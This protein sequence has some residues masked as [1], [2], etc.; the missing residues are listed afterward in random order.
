[1]NSGLLDGEDMIIASPT[2]SGKTLIA[3]L[4]MINKTVKKDETAIYIVPLKSL[5]S[6]KF[7]D[8]KERFEDQKVHISVGDLDDS[9]EG[10]ET[11]DIVVVTSEKLDS[12]LRHNPSWINNIGLVVVDEIHLLTSEERGTTLEV[13][14]SRLQELLEFQLL[15]LSATISN[16]DE[17]A[18]WLDAELIESE[19]RPV[20]LEHGIHWNHKV[21]FYS[22]EEKEKAEESSS[23]TGSWQTGAEIK[24][25]G[26]SEN[27][28]REIDI[29]NKYEKATQNLILDTLEKE[30][31]SITFCSSRKGAEKASDR[32]SEV[33]E[34][35][36][37]REERNELENY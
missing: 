5:A 26:F 13:T 21:K 8:F 9:G 7:Q 3:E 30:K 27:N 10:H 22:E 36:L 6:E 18:D 33:T 19:Y 11:A 31:Q 2:A 37:T 17:L 12:M 29:K 35:K 1:M 24:E 28:T 4:A 16:S 14:I 32:A 25:K 15:G 34:D 20:D 23:D